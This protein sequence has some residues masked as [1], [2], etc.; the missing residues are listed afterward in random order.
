MQE[1]YLNHKPG[2]APSDAGRLRLAA[3]AAHSLSDGD[4]VSLLPCTLQFCS[5]SLLLVYGSGL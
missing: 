5:R 2:N 3:R 1:N 4:L